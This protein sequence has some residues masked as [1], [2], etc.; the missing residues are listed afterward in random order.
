M[1][2]G[3]GVGGCLPFFGETLSALKPSTTVSESALVPFFQVAENSEAGGVSFL[4]RPT[5]WLFYTL[6]PTAV[7]PAAAPV[8]HALLH[9]RAWLAFPS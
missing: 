8:V 3:V 7:A 9:L 4:G 1:T 5:R 6:S 2:G